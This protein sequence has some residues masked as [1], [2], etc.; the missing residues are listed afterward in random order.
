IHGKV[1]SSVE[2][3]ATLNG[4]PLEFHPRRE[5]DLAFT[6]KSAFLKTGFN[7]LVFQLTDK[8]GYTKTIKK[9]I[10]YIGVQ[11][12][13][14]FVEENETINDKVILTGNSTPL[15][16]VYVA[17]PGKN[18]RK[19]VAYFKVSE[20]GKFSIEVPL[21]PGQN[22]FHIYSVKDNKESPVI[23]RKITRKLSE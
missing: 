10:E 5:N 17:I 11:V 4:I 9:T 2:M 15:S 1:S 3:V 18:K 14:S 16:N 21:E 12:N 8:E 6:T 7:S 23:V 20:I 22:I 19:I 13:A